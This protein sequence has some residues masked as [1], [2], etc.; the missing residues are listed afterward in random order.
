[1][2]QRVIVYRKRL[3]AVVVVVVVGRGEKLEAFRREEEDEISVGKL[4]VIELVA[5][6]KLKLLLL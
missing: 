6:I 1:L 2:Y 4:F 5:E 3:A